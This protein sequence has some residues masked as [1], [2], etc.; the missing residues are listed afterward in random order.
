MTRLVGWIGNASADRGR[1]IGMRKMVLGTAVLA[2]LLTAGCAGGTSVT[3]SAAPS[4]PPAWL[5]EL[6]CRAAVSLHDPSPSSAAYVQGGHQQ[7]EQVASGDIIYDPDTPVYLV[8][9]IGDF[10]GAQV[11]PASNEIVPT[12]HVATFTVAL[13]THRVLDAGIQDATPDLSPLGTP[14]TLPTSCG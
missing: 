7:A 14:R 3:T 10:V 6:A 5:S 2:A 9:L 1:L 8:V 12:G 11:G 13:D 4:P